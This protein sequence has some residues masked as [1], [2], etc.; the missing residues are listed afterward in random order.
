MSYHVRLSVGRG[1]DS[2]LRIHYYNMIQVVYLM[3]LKKMIMMIVDKKK[4][5]SS[6]ETFNSLLSPLDVSLALGLEFGVIHS[7]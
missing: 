1:R 6:M 4:G 5:I 2:K 7:S 3:I